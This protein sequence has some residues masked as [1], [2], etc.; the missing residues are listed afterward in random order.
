M[1]SYSDRYRSSYNRRSGRDVEF[2][3][4]RASGTAGV[5]QLTRFGAQATAMVAH[6][7]SKARNFINRFAL[8]PKRCKQPADLRRS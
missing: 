6:R 5:Q 4:S 2:M 7:L 1:F 8:D 3:N